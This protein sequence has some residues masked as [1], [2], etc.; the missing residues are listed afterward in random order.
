MVNMISTTWGYEAN[1]TAPKT[2]KNMALKELEVG[3]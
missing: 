2:V 3:R 1:V